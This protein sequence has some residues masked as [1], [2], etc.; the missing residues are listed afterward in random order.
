IYP[1]DRRHDNRAG[2]TGHI[3]G[4]R[5]RHM[6]YRDLIAQLIRAFGCRSYLEV[7]VAEGRTFFHQTCRLKV[8]VDPRFRL[9]LPAARKSEPGSRFFEE[10]SDAFFAGHAAEAGPFDLIF[11]D[12]L[13][14]AEQIIRDFLNSI[15]HLSP[16]GIIVIDDV[17][18]DS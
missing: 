3:C 16:Q 12:G 17:W 15:L 7:G 13:H 1:T 11:L 18:P 10:T 8:A 2:A 4:K 5:A 6:E 9:D 14:T